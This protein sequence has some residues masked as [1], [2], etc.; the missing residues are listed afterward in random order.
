MG[1]PAE[2]RVVVV[3]TGVTV[4]GEACDQKG[5]RECGT[6]RRLYRGV[7]AERS[8]PRCTPEGLAQSTGR[9]WLQESAAGGRSGRPRWQRRIAMGKVR[10]PIERVDAPAQTILFTLVATFLR[11]HG[12]LRCGGLQILQNKRFG[13]KIR[14]GDKGP[15]LALCSGHWRSARSGASVLPHPAL[16]PAS[17]PGRAG[18]TSRHRVRPAQQRVG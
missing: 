2:L 16:P 3:E 10:R 12:D 9:R 17:P 13:C 6:G 15:L 5:I 1:E 18:P 7:V 14:I 11:Q 4:V 8:Q